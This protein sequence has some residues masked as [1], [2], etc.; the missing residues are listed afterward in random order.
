MNVPKTLNVVEMAITQGKNLIITHRP[1]SSVVHA[2]LNSAIAVTGKMVIAECDSLPLWDM[3]IID[4]EAEVLVF[5][6]FQ[7]AEPL[8]K[9]RIRALMEKKSAE[10]VAAMPKLN[11]VVILMQAPDEPDYLTD[12]TDAVAQELGRLAPSIVVSIAG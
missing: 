10:G 5:V 12:D 11:T 8:V 4:S 2:T 3:Q 6:E 7:L 1:G 9:E